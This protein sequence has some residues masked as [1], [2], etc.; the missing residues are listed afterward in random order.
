MTFS[1]GSASRSKL[2]GVHPDL[3]RVVERAIQLTSIDFKLTEG[4]RTVERQRQ[5]VREGKSKTMNSR[6]LTGHAI[7]FAALV[8]GQVN[9][10]FQHYL[11]IAEAFF[12]AAKELGVAI[13]WGGSWNTSTA[14]W[15]ATRFKDGPHVELVASAYP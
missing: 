13:R 2:V 15:Q 8:G 5:L 11:T 6:H 4:L 14:G 9:W 7:D 3:V 12:K 1:L 10:D